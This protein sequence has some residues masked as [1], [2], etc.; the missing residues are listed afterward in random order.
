MA[1]IN[2][3]PI[4]KWVL[5]MVDRADL[6][7]QLSCCGS[8]CVTFELLLTEEQLG[9]GNCVNNILYVRHSNGGQLYRICLQ[10]TAGR[11]RSTL[12]TVYYR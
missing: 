9:H 6:H 8:Q 3:P 10:S 5:T 12:L 4:T 1:V 2:K 7:L 11:A